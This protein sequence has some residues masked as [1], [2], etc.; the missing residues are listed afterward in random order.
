MVSVDIKDCEVVFDYEEENM[1]TCKTDYFLKTVVEVY[2]EESC[3]GC[4]KIFSRYK[5]SCV[6]NYFRL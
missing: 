2:T 1:V 3:C 4:D 5:K 6:H